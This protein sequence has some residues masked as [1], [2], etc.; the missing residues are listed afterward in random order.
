MTDDTTDDDRTDAEEIPDPDT[1]GD[2][3]ADPDPDPGTDRDQRADADLTSGGV[4]EVATGPAGAGGDEE[5]GTDDEG[6]VY[7]GG[8]SGTRS[9]LLWTA[10]VVLSLLAVVALFQF[11]LNASAAIDR[12]VAPEYRRMM[13]ALFNLVV[14]LVSGIGIAMVV[15]ELGE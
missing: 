14:L 9:K 11:Y 2:A 12:W 1:R 15:R 5:S 8:R 10:L 6:E 4:T 7:D 13:Q 3:G